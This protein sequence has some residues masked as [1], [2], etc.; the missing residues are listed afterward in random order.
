VRQVR[1]TRGKALRAEPVS[2]L[3]EQGKAHIV[4]VD[5]TNLEDQMVTFVPGSPHSPDRLDAAVWAATGLMQ[6]L[7]NTRNVTDKYDWHGIDR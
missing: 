2:A 3:W 6:T 7:N 4:G 1:A 5:M